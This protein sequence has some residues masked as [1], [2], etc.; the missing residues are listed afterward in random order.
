[1]T[2]RY[3]TPEELAQL[4]LAKGCVSTGH[5]A[6]RGDIWLNNMGQSFSVPPPPDS[7]GYPAPLVSDILFFADPVRLQMGIGPLTLH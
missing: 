2:E 1:M 4:L 7:R 3:H 5:K 6:G